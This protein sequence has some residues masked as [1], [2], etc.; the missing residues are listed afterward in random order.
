MRL[1]LALLL[2]CTCAVAQVAIPP[3][4]SRV[5]D[6][7]GTLDAA[8]IQRIEAPL[9]AIEASKG[10]QV[11]VLIV[12]TTGD[13]S[14]EAYALR[15]FDAWNL[16]RKG[17][18][19]GIL[20]VVAK[21]DRTVRIEVGYGLE[22]AVPDV[23]AH[24]VIQ[25]YLVPR[26]REGDFAGGIR[27]AVGALGKLIEGETLPAPMSDHASSSSD[28]QVVMP[29]LMFSLVLASFAQVFLRW[30]PRVVRAPL[31]AA[32]VGAMAR[33]IFG[34]PWWLSVVAAA[35]GFGFGLMTMTAGSVARSGGYGGMGSGRSGGGWSGGGSSGGSRSSSGGG[36]SGGGGRSGGGGASGRW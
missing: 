26:F 24:R 18:D 22:G 7:T 23:S 5:T 35:I 27:A 30:L 33:V 14:I 21:N 6:T 34:A 20:L 8:A 1:A 3:L 16:G 28:R 19:D 4:S 13:E 17:V 12:P 29:V 32:A 15:A 11:A 2:F 36:F 31:I 9:A 25:E 10:A